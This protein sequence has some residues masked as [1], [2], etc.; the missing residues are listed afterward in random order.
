MLQLKTINRRLLAVQAAAAAGALA[1]SLPAEA[2]AQTQTGV[3]FGDIARN[4]TDSIGQLPALLSGIAYMMGLMLGVL[5]IL[6]LKDHVE[7][8]SQTP[9]KDGAIRL[10]SGGALFAL[11]IV[12][13]AMKNTI[14][15]S[16]DS[17]S[18]AHLRAIDFHTYN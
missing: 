3:D 5:G 7:N 15:T 13:E 17:V 2:Q 9:M 11:P 4:V 16:G 1:A 18:A 6:K 10:A 12:F 8:P 14:G